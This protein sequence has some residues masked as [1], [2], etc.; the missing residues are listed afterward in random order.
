MCVGV[1]VWCVCV[2]M[3]VC[4]YVKIDNSNKIIYI[5]LYLSYVFSRAINGTKSCTIINETVSN[6]GRA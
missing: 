6:S 5:S 1:C 2:C 4:V 3:S